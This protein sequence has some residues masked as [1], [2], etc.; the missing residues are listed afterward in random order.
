M[1]CA[2]CVSSESCIKVVPVKQIIDKHVFM[3]HVFF[4]IYIFEKEYAYN[5][6]C[7]YLNVFIFPDKNRNR[8]L[9]SSLYLKVL[10]VCPVT[11]LLA[12]KETF[13]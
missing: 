3:D 11:V 6:K 7:I 10:S 4:Q 9:C 12:E 8:L 13:N 1:L 5:F 2:S